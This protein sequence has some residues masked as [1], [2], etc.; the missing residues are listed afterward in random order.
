MSPF[1]C[2]HCNFST[3]YRSNLTRHILNK[4]RDV[5]EVKV[6]KKEVKMDKGQN[7]EVKVDKKEVK[8][9]KHEDKDEI[10]CD[11]CGAGFIKEKYLKQHHQNGK[12]RGVKQLQ[13]KYCKVFL[14]TLGARY[15]HEQR[16][17]KKAITSTDIDCR[18]STNNIE[19]Q[20]ILNKLST[21]LSQSTNNNQV[22]PINITLVN[23]TQIQNNNVNT[24]NNNVLVFP[25]K[26]SDEFHADVSHI[27]NNIQEFAKNIRSYSREEQPMK[28]I[29]AVFDNPANL[30]IIKPNMRSNYSDIHIGDGIWQK[31]SDK[32]AYP[33]LAY[34]ASDTFLGLM[35]K[36]KKPFQEEGI[37]HLKRDVLNIQ[38]GLEAVLTMI[39]DATDEEKK[40]AKV[41]TQLL[42]L[43]AYNKRVLMN[44]NT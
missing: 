44:L 4:H 39:E 8:M 22:H 37:Y 41:M 30:P 43:K 29:E 42:Q 40:M 27:E 2:E 36:N 20:D 23:S 34:H 14:S 31:I 10:F 7:R 24:I 15:K 38:L 28:A 6:D 16:C 12:C 32:E 19:L 18:T 11:M 35:K 5:L 33:K 13:C 17:D 3:I 21:I 26:T 9:D 1:N 25:Q